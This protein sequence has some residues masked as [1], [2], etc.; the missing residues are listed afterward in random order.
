LPQQFESDP[1]KFAFVLKSDPA[2][3][4]KSQLF[5]NNKLVVYK[6]KRGKYL[7]IDETKSAQEIANILVGDVLTGGG[8]W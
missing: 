4:S 5:N 7:S 8:T 2:Y 1:F 3:L 6:A